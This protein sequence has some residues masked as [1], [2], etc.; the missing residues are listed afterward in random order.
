[1]LRTP[2]LPGDSDMNQIKTIFH[3]LGTPT[4]EDW[5]VRISAYIVDTEILNDAHMF[6]QG[7]TK[8]PDYVSLG[9]FPKTPLRLLFTAA[10]AD[11]LDLL[12]RMLTYDPRKRC[13][14]MEVAI[15]SYA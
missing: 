2:Y 14:A 13:N 6:Q 4:E 9:Q 12:S 1:M 8:L 11:A 3:A 7:H 15:L 5:P 10:S